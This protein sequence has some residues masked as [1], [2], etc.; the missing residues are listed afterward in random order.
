MC[1][2]RA[3]ILSCLA[4][5]FFLR[6]SCWE[7]CYTRAASR[8]FFYAKK[9]Y[10]SVA[11]KCVILGRPPQK[12]LEKSAFFEGDRSFFSENGPIT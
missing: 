8:S 2:T 10:V 11:G 4:L 6:F 3:A 12:K 1:Y 5:L 9:V 7:M